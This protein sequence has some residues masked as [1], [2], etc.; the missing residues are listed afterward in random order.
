[1][2]GLAVRS[3]GYVEVDWQA[4]DQTELLPQVDP[5]FLVAKQAMVVGALMRRYA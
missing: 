5:G 2:L 4:R 1:M 3:Q